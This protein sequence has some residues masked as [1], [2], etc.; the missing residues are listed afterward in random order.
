MNRPPGREQ[1]NILAEVA[2]SQEEQL[3]AEQEQQQ[4]LQQQL[5]QTDQ[6]A[7]A[8]A[9]MPMGMAWGGQQAG[10]FMGQQGFMPGAYW[11]QAMV[12][13]PQMQPIAQQRHASLAKPEHAGE[14]ASERV[15]GGHRVL[16]QTHWFTV[17][18]GVGIAAL[19]A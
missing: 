17:C 19:P 1:L 6:W 5:M 14:R 15:G 16:L 10:M 4:Q 7:A 3:M 13:Q 9:A 8:V 11:P 2:A 18:C 12:A